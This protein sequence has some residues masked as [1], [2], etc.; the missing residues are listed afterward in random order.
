[1]S[2]TEPSNVFPAIVFAIFVG[3]IGL[4]AL[5]S[6]APT[7]PKMPGV[8]VI[9]AP[10][11]QTSPIGAES[12]AMQSETPPSNDVDVEGEAGPS[13]NPSVS[14]GSEAPAVPAPDVKVAVP[15]N[16]KTSAAPK[17]GNNESWQ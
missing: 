11:I 4:G 10:E 15:K 14:P 7:S 9:A 16:S 5:Y 8:K 3:V 6:G 2:K 12:Q 13:V 17:P 1:M